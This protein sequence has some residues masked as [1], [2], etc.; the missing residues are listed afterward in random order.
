[1]TGHQPRVDPDVGDPPSRRT[2]R[3]RTTRAVAAVEQ[4]GRDQPGRPDSKQLDRAGRDLARGERPEMTAEPAPV[5]G[6]GQVVVAANGG[7]AE[8]GNSH[9]RLALAS[10]RSGHGQ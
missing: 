8:A 9:R 1:G 5:A 6:P 7:G 4:E 3:P 2:A 10:F